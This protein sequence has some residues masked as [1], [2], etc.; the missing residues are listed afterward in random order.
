MFVK[1]HLSA[2][3]CAVVLAAGALA[4][5]A[6]PLTLEG[7]GSFAAGGTVVPAQEKY[8]PYHPKAE[9]QDLHGDHAFVRWQKPVDARRFPLVFLHGAGQFSKT[10]ETTPDG[11]DGFNNIFLS[12]G[13]SVWLV[14]QPRRGGAGKATVPGSIAGKSDEAFFFGQFR[15]GMWPKFNEG[16]QFPQDAESI[17]QFFRQMTP[18][19]APYDEMVNARAMTEVLKRSGRAVLVTHSQG[20]GI[21][22]QT[23]MMSDN[24]AGI[25]SYEPGSGFP[26]PEGE[27]PAPLKTSSF[28]GDFPV[29]IVPVAEFDKLTRYPIVIYYGDYIPKSP[30]THPHEDYW[31]AALELA[32]LWADCVNRHGGDAKVIELPDAGLR[33][34]SH[35]PF[36]ERNNVEVADLLSKWLHGKKLDVR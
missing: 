26:F 28:F 14:D 7:Q 16:S 29:K 18:N 8:D 34:N 36:A 22:W 2:V 6:A 24:L 20:G 31:R 15:M 9:A 11:R 3:A 32:R 35:F 13:F 12:R 17:N 27:A 25:V 23:G 21:G 33:G 5:S 30:T 19:T 10:W 4:V 1:N